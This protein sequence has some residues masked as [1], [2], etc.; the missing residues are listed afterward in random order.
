MRDRVTFRSP[1]H[2]WIFTAKRYIVLLNNWRSRI[3]KI[4]KNK[5]SCGEVH[6]FEEMSCISFF[7]FSTNHTVSLSLTTVAINLIVQHIQDILTGGL[8]KRLNGWFN[9]YGTTKKQPNME[10]SSR[11]HW[12]QC[13]PDERT[14]G[15][16]GRAEYTAAN[17]AGKS[18]G[19]LL[20]GFCSDWRS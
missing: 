10:S 7:F 8:T 2:F 9:G 17:E 6:V 11:P 3:K 18:K 13:R 4:N 12:A 14:A 19:R 15:S 5:S 16:P 20:M 1:K